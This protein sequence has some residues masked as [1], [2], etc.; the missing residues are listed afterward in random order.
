MVTRVRQWAVFPLVFFGLLAAG[1]AAAERGYAP[2]AVVAANLVAAAVIALLERVM[3][4][5]PSWNRARG[6]VKTDVLHMLLSTVAMPEVIRALLFGGLAAVGSW[7][8][9]RTGTGLWPTG[10]GL[11]PQ[12]VLALVVSEF[13]Q[14][15]M[16]RWMHTTELLWRLH[17]VHHSAGRLYWLNAGRFHP[18]DTLCNFTL[19]AG[20]LILLGCPGDVVALFALFTGVHGLFQH[21]NLDLKLGPLNWFFSMAEL[22]RWHHSR[23][24]E[25]SNSN[26]GANVILWDIVFRTRLLPPGD[27]PREP[28]FD[29]M[30][31]FPA[32][33]L[34]QLASPVTF[35]SKP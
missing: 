9:D 14:Y 6:D 33:Y 23:V 28:G 15:W 17:A 24:P 2:H 3:P 31:E 20:P 27:P 8:A 21:G 13:G 11:L 12:L 4:F 34:A 22:H 25:E 1:I 19:Q 35:F 16:H 5:E 32:G 18:L 7:L 26:Y 30:E 29:G 10:W